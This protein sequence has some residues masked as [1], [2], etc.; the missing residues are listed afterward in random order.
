MKQLIEAL[1]A[2]ARDLAAK[3]QP[4]HF[5][6]A[7]LVVLALPLL[8]L[9]VIVNYAV[10]A[11]AN[12]QPPITHVWFY[13]LNDGNL[14]P[15]PAGTLSPIAAPSAP[16]DPAKRA[17]RAHVFSCGSCDAGSFIA[18]LTSATPRYRALLATGS[19]D[20]DE[21]V[22]K[23]AAESSQYEGILHASAD[24]P[25]QWYVVT[26]PETVELLRAPAR[27]CAGKADPVEC[28]P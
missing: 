12:D 10:T 6:M 3:M 16:D 8:A 5:A 23:L 27:E 19:D 21:H 28:F 7:G 4:R 20:I 17:V 2:P 25:S 1:P 11:P 26:A 18:Y 22:E 14:Y 13:D 24:N 9:S 15:Q